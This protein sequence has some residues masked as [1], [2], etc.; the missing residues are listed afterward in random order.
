MR[1]AFKIHEVTHV[2]YECRQTESIVH[3]KRFN[4]I[5]NCIVFIERYVMR[6]S[7]IAVQTFAPLRTASC[8]P[9]IVPYPTQCESVPVDPWHIAIFTWH[10]VY[11]YR[12]MGL[13]WHCW[14]GKMFQ[15]TC[16]NC[17]QKFD[18]SVNRIFIHMQRNWL[19]LD[20]MRS[21]GSSRTNPYLFGVCK[22][23][24]V[25]VRFLSFACTRNR[26]A[27]HNQSNSIIANVN[28]MER[29]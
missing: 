6:E 17:E 18:A 5:D 22:T 29:C 12:L 24:R 1:C 15:H 26:N 19:Q 21:T 8:E 14:S 16:V 25:W 2:R 23:F 27:D 20:I 10:V 13:V 4:Y 11:C 3:L 28:E 7:D 9:P